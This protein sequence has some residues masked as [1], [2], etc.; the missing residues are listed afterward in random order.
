MNPAHHA[1]TWIKVERPTL[2]LVGVVLS[3]FQIAGVL[4]VLAVAVGGLLGVSLIV[5]RRRAG[6][7]LMEAV[8][9]R[10]DAS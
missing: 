4:L 9:L 10:L 5:V 8:S 6:A 3:S 2:D 1:I 7:P